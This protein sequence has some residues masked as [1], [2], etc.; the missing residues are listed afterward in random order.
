MS[1]KSKS[2]VRLK[3]GAGA[4]LQHFNYFTLMR[5]ASTKDRLLQALGLVTSIITGVALVG[6]LQSP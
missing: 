1:Q 5:Y 3:K 6:H 2:V 4:E